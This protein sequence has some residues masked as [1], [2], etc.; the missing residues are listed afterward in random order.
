M[1]E[2]WKLIFWAVMLLWLVGGL[3][4]LWDRAVRNTYANSI[5]VWLLFAILGAYAIGSPGFPGK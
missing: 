5:I 3:G 2:F 1:G 4:W